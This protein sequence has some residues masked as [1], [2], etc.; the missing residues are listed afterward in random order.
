MFVAS[1]YTYKL[2]EHGQ[3]AAAAAA[4][5]AALA[6]AAPAGG[7]TGGGGGAAPPPSTPPT[8]APPR[9]SPGLPPRPRASSP[10]SLPA[11]VARA[12]ASGLVAARSLVSAGSYLARSLVPRPDMPTD[13]PR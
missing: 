3:P 12:G 5:A 2:V 7:A 1:R 8:P 10:I 9:V 4:T 13:F 11:A 6:A